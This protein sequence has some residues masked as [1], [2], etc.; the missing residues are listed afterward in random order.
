[1]VTGLCYYLGLVDAR[2]Y[3]GHFGIDTNSL[4]LTSSDYVMRS[5]SVYPL[6]VAL[7]ALYWAALWGREYAKRA[8]RRDRHPRLV[9]YTAWACVALGITLTVR[10]IV[11]AP[12]RGSISSI[13]PAPPR[14][15][16]VSVQ[17]C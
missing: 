6:I 16:S 12:C 9:R 13:S 15:H 2:K 14:R 10:G 17:A 1:M 11:G 5:V 8:I 4:G 7:L 3:Y